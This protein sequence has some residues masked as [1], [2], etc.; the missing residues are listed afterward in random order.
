MHEDVWKCLRMLNVLQTRGTSADIWKKLHHQKLSSSLARPVSCGHHVIMSLV[1][2]AAAGDVLG[3]RKSLADHTDR[4]AGGEGSLCEDLS[5]LPCGPVPLARAC[6]ALL[7]TSSYPLFRFYITSDSSWAW[8]VDLCPINSNLCW[9][10][11]H[12]FLPDI[13][14]VKEATCQWA[15]WVY[16]MHYSLLKTKAYNLSTYLG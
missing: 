13:F 3:K 9:N 6:L 15:S 16:F 14:T 11:S 12:Y 5:T 7:A 10:L 2:P 8:L 1:Q 4:H